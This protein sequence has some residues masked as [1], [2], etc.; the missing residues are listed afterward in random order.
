M[1]TGQ[2]AAD[3]RVGMDTGLSDPV[4]AWAGAGFGGAR[5]WRLDSE[6]TPEHL[7]GTETMNRCRYE[8]LGRTQI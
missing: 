3:S 1:V 8:E 2:R 7:A 6:N 5:L 4:S